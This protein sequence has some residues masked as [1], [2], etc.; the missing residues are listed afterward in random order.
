MKN[1]I[2]YRS[3]SEIKQAITANQDYQNILSTDVL[4]KGKISQ[5]A[6][7]WIMLQNIIM[8]CVESVD[9]N[10]LYIAGD[11]PVSVAMDIV[12]YI[13]RITALKQADKD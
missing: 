6:L 4:T 3:E 11:L 10:T 12:D 8:L 1:N 7:A 5:V 9:G 13:Q 2:V